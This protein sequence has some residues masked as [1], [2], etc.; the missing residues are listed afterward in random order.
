M[1]VWLGGVGEG[2]LV[3]RQDKTQPIEFFLTKTCK[4]G[5]YSAL[6]KEGSSPRHRPPACHPPCAHGDCVQNECVCPLG[7]GLWGP[8]CDRLCPG[9][10]GSLKEGVCSGHG[11]C[12]A[13]DG[14]CACVAGFSGADCAQ[15]AA[16]GPCALNCS[17]HGVCASGG[18]EGRCWCESGW[19]GA[20]C[21]ES[22]C[23][24][25]SH[26]RCLH[27]GEPVCFCEAGWGGET[28]ELPLG[29]APPK[30]CLNDCHGHG[31]CDPVL[32][33]C[34]CLQAYDGAD[35]RHDEHVTCPRHCS[36]HG[37]CSQHGFCYC[38]PDFQGPDCSVHLSDSGRRDSRGRVGLPATSSR[39]HAL[40]GAPLVRGDN[41]SSLLEGGRDGDT[42]QEEEE[43]EE[44]GTVAEHGEAAA[45]QG[46]LPDASTAAQPFA[47]GSK[48]SARAPARPVAAANESG[49][50]EAATRNMAHSNEAQAQ[51]RQRQVPPHRKRTSSAGDE[52]HFPMVQF[53]TWI[54]LF[55]LAA[56]FFFGQQKR[57][58]GAR[59]ARPALPSALEP[60]RAQ[61]LADRAQPDDWN[62]RRGRD[63]AGEEGFGVKES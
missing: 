54:L 45:W 60:P 6:R 37:R 62:A 12:G 46:G 58:P 24:C 61:T 17:G 14:R 23:A 48:A 30:R 25:S 28:C 36:G 34:R 10:G 57:G 11:R 5:P 31:F 50:L 39:L 27:A 4:D 38:M 2:Q 55:A 33:L 35:C 26:G 9:A 43:G 15:P 21:E 63:G 51:Q 3:F 42:S 56:V 49:A 59:P 22:L 1:C 8:A 7:A 44:G 41:A 29:G 52:S 47:Q 19:R 18:G 32:G 40:P 13:S 16:A 53:M 20:A